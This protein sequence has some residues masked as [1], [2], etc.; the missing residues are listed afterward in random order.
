[1]KRLLYSILL[2]S[3]FSY[4][5]NDEFNTYSNGLI[6]DDETIQKLG[7]IVDSLNLKFRTCDLSHP[8]YSLE[9]GMANFIIIR[10]ARARKHIREG[11][12]Y[13]EFARRFPSNIKEKNIWIVKNRYADEEKHLINYAGLPYGWNK[14]P[15]IMV[16]DNESNN[17]VDGWVVSQ[18]GKKAF[19]LKNLQALELPVAYARLVQYVDCLIDTSGQIYFPD[20]E[21]KIHPNPEKGSV[22]EQFI[23]WSAEFPGRPS[24]PDYENIDHKDYDSIYAIFNE[25][26][27]TWDSLRLQN[28]DETMK[29]NT[30]LKQV[31]VQARDEAIETGNSNHA[32]E[33][34]IARYLSKE[35]ALRLKR[36]RRVIGF[37]SMDLGPRYHAVN[38]CQLAA[39]T[40]KWDIFLRAH[41][42]IMNDRFERVADGSYAW[43]SRKTYLKELEEL[44]IE[45]TD[46][47]LGTCLR[48]KNVSDNHYLGYISRIGRALSDTDDKDQLETRI[49]SMIQDDALDSYNRLL[50]AYLFI[51]YT[52]NLE[53]V[54]RKKSAMEKFSLTLETLPEYIRTVWN[55]E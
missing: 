39:Q 29:T 8:Y 2:V 32:L 43:A 42:D 45:A 38:I 51:H 15:S 24:Y 5:Q 14:E 41:L 52:K 18:N 44:D 1:M 17:K 30:H 37:C 55:K 12:S 13:E 36:N 54:E 35:D 28:L 11:I 34:Y 22:A 46:L 20:A 27:E 53:E 4:G 50:L 25:K 16:N 19:Y 40:A 48:V 26:Y 21:R 47:L 49:L 33:F 9:Q 23:Q 7:E 31:L 3:S 6:Y 10:S